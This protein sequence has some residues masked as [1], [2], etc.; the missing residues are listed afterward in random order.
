MFRKVNIFIMAIVAVI[1]L[2]MGNASAIIMHSMDLNQR[3]I[4]NA[5]PSVGALWT[6]ELDGERRL[7]SV[8]NYNQ[9]WGIITHHQIINAGEPV[10]VVFGGNAFTTPM[11]SEIDYYVISP[12]GDDLA[13]VHYATPL[14]DIQGNTIGT[15][16]QIGDEIRFGGFGYYGVPYNVI[17]QDG[18]SRAADGSI[19]GWVSHGYND[20]FES[21]WI[22]PYYEESYELGGLGAPGDSGSIAIR[23]EDGALLGITKSISSANIYDYYTKTQFVDLTT[24]HRRNWIENTAVFS[25]VPAPNSILLFEMG[26][27]LFIGVK[28]KHQ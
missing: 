4:D 5:V 22:D 17:G 26:L 3:Y 24:E 19:T 18:N 14:P 27:L 12:F 2:S 23:I 28:R 6:E 21:T 1:L 10:G 13:L 8:I 15:S 20:M 9:R 7:S 16:P 11:S 25:Q